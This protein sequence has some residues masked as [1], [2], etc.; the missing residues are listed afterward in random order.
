MRLEWLAPQLAKDGPLLERLAFSQASDSSL[1]VVAAFTDANGWNS[2]GKTPMDLACLERVRWRRAEKNWPGV[3]VQAGLENWPLHVAIAWRSH[4]V[5]R[6]RS[7][8][9]WD[10]LGMVITDTVRW[11]HRG[12]PLSCP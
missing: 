9:S 3:R 4:D 6:G 11:H 8:W 5:Q 12:F 2:H 1:Q 7:E 10:T